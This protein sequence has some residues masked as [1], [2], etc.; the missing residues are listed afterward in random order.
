MHD[1]AHELDH[2]V[3]ESQSDQ[4]DLTVLQRM[5]G[6]QKQSSLA[7]IAGSTHAAAQ[8]AAVFS[9]EDIIHQVQ[10]SASLKFPPLEFLHLP[11]RPPYPPPA[12][13]PSLSGAACKTRLEKKQ[14]KT[15]F[16][17]NSGLKSM[18]FLET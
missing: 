11:Y 3:L 16:S 8:M 17:H 2:V 6:F 12:Q 13:G 14:G 5:V 10:G 1:L 15:I 4:D 9:N 18:H 7:D